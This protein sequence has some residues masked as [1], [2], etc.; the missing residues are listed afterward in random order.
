MARQALILRPVRATDLDALNGLVERAVGTW[1][2]PERVKRL[3][4]P[5]Y[6]YT[7]DDLQALCLVGAWREHRLLGVVAWEVDPE[8]GLLGLHG[9]YVDPHWWHQGVGSTLLTHAERAAREQGLRQIQVKAQAGARDFF[10]RHGFEPVPD[11]QARDYAHLFSKPVA[12]GHE[13]EEEK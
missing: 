6:R 8:R 11:P 12:P 1:D 13:G 9:L 3:A 10:Q 2:L 4:M 5:T 7:T